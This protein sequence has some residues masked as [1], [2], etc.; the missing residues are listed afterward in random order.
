MK[1]NTICIIRRYILGQSIA[2]NAVQSGR[3]QESVELILT[4]FMYLVL[5]LILF[6]GY[7]TTFLNQEFEAPK[8]PQ[9]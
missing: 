4:M 9:L 2:S 3:K 7:R 8:K 6:S 1:Y 5:K